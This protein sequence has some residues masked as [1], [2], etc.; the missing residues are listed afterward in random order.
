MTDLPPPPAIIKTV[1]SPEK[2][3]PPGVFLPKITPMANNIKVDGLQKK[4]PTEIKLTEVIELKADQQNYDEKTK[5]VTA[6]GHVVLKYKQAILTSDRL[7]VNMTTKIAV[8][9]GNVTL[10]RGQQILK[11]DRFEYSLEEDRGTIFN[12]IGDIDQKAIAKDSNLLSPSPNINTSEILTTSPVSGVSNVGNYTISLG[13]GK[14]A[15]NLPQNPSGGKINKF[16]FQA[17]KINFM[18]EEWEGE[19]IRITNDPFSPPEI[20]LRANTAK[21]KTLPSGEQELR[22]SGSRLVFDQNFALPIFQNRLVLNKK[23]KQPPIIYLG[24]DNGDKGGLFMFRTFYPINNDNLSLSITPQFHIQKA[25]ESNL[26]AGAFGLISQLEATLNP[27]TKITGKADIITFE[28]DLIGDK[29]RANLRLTQTLGDKQPHKLNLEYNYRDRLFNGSLGFQTVQSSFGAVLTSPDIAL[30]KTGIN[31]NY[32][33]SVQYINAD[34]DRQELLGINPPNNRVSLARYQGTASLN[35]GFL[36][37]QGKPLEATETAGIKY[38]PTPLVP[39]LS[40]G[41]GI[42]GVFTSYSNG[43]SQNSLSGSVGLQWQIGHLSKPY[44]DY[45]KLNL[46]YSKIVPTGSSPFLFDRLADNQVM[47]FGITQQIYGGLLLGY[48][49]AI[50]LDNSQQISTDYLLEYSRRSYN[51][52]LRY[53]PNL[54]VGLIMFRLND[55]N[56]SGTPAPF[57]NIQQINQGVN[58]N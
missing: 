48:Q 10:T 54:Q 20:E 3:Q 43:D 58:R 19:Q 36:L 5:L 44:L 52:S 21:L 40:L 57:D 27:R 39:S 33:G 28:P 45:T 17:G 4:E 9:E 14:E 51:I 53:N 42:M 24:F 29:T 26:D 41:T 2:R 30:G 13:G 15:S 22:S 11:G 8:A 35:K 49:T 38:T 55:F 18:G 6:E 37:W 47:S 56:W 7:E 46:G 12:A 34:T 1:S 32:Q 50:N 25:I 23:Q 16:R 31:L